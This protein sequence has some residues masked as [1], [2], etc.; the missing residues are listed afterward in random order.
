MSLCVTVCVCAGFLSPKSGASARARSGDVHDVVEV[1]DEEEVD[2]SLFTVDPSKH[3]GN[4][5][6]LY[7]LKAFEDKFRRAVAQF[8]VDCNI[9]AAVIGKES[10]H[11]MFEL[12][13]A[14][15][16]AWIPTPR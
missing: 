14:G 9:A 4:S 13:V 8:L 12:L 7:R 6:L 15:S 3:N 5:L 10:F 11:A 16:S 1:E 2:Q